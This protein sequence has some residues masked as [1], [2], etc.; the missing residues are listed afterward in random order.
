MDKGVCVQCK[1]LFNI[2]DD[3]VECPTC[4]AVMGIA[5]WDPPQ[6]ELLE[7]GVID[8]GKAESV[9]EQNLN[10]Y[11]TG[12]RR[13]AAGLVDGVILLPITL[14]DSWALASSP[15]LP[16]IWLLISYPAGWV[17]S[18]LMHGY[19]GQTIGKMVCGLKVLDISEHPIT[20]RQAFLRDSP[21]I[22]INT[23]SLVTSIYIV[24]MGKGSRSRTLAN[25][26]WFVGAAAF[27]WFAAELLTLLTNKK[28]RAIHD[29][30]AGT[31]VVKTGRRVWGSKDL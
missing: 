4:G 30:I 7:P 19:Y 29:F 15:P 6:L 14:I 3:I 9:T 17:Y 20:M 21:I 10:S 22:V 16:A 18:V 23:L 27:M 5:G 2:S 25:I 26:E 1:A 12:A 28:R 13:V 11:S 8:A 31:V 24:L